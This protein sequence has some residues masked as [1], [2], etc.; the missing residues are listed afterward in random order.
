MIPLL[1]DSTAT[2][3]IT[4]SSIVCSTSG[5]GWRIWHGRG[6]RRVGKSCQREEVVI[7]Q[8]SHFHDKHEK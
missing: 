3:I 6:W 5:L 1:D 7:G 4:I 8:R 2:E